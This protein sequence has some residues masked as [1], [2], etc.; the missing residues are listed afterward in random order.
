[1]PLEQIQPL[2]TAFGA[3]I[4]L[5]ELA[6]DEDGY[7]GL[8]FDEVEVHLQ[9]DPVNDDLL[10][11][12]PLGQLNDDARPTGAELLLQANLFWSGT[13]GATLAMQPGDHAVMLHDRQAAAALDDTGLERWIETFV[14]V[15]E[16]WVGIINELNER[17]GQPA[18]DAAT[19]PPGLIQV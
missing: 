11:F 13:G 7:A 15:A 16:Q 17:G 4:E 12:T 1:M 3:R 9:F 10:L 2:I 19:E 14:S 6:L 18:D 8:T 5:P